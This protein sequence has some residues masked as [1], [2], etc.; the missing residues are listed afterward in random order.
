MSTTLYP[1]N[2][3]YIVTPGDLLSDVLESRGIKQKELAQS[4]EVTPKH[5]NQIIKGTVSVTLET[6]RK[7]ERVLG[8]PASFWLNAEN[9]YRTFLSKQKE[10]LAQHKKILSSSP[11]CELIKRGHSPKDCS[12]ADA[13]ECVLKFF[14]VVS[15]EK[16]HEHWDSPQMSVALRHSQKVQGDPIALATWLRIG[17][18]HLIQSSCEPYN[19]QKFRKALRE[20]RT[21]TTSSSSEFIPKMKELCASGGVVFLPIPEIKGSAVNGA[22]LWLSGKTSIMLNLRGKRNDIFWFTFFHEAGHIL[23]DPKT[24]CID[25]GVSDKS[26]EREKRADRFASNFLIPSTALRSRLRTLTSKDSIIQ[27]ANDIGIHPGVVLGRLQHE[28]R[29]PRNRYNELK[30]KFEWKPQDQE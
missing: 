9:H 21:L 1:Y 4:I 19:E 29:I 15:I 22:T 8:I 27:F 24:D 20:I 10:N 25:T 14:G 2:P 17:H 13:V 18:H 7:L 5:I 26:D 28:G 16:L 6:A 11:I 23:C 3:D 30:V 12:D